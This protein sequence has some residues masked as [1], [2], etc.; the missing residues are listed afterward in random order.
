VP[1]QILRVVLKQ[2]LVVMI[3]VL[4]LETMLS[5]GN[6]VLLAPP[7]LGSAEVGMSAADMIPATQDQLEELPRG[8]GIDHAEATTAILTMVVKPA[9]ALHQL[10]PGN[11]HLPILLP[12]LHLED[13]Q[14]TLLLD[15]VRTTKET[16]A[17][18]LVLLLRLG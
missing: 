10:L 13:I 14:V 3:K 12:V 17:H 11:K 9:M 8:P 4:L 15:M 16:W 1:P 5:H 7:P 2:V 6:V 18:L